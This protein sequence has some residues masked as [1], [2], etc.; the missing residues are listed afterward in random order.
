[1]KRHLYN[2]E[3]YEP[4]PIWQQNVSSKFSRNSETSASEFLEMFPLYFSKIQSRTPTLKPMCYPSQKGEHAKWCLLQH[5]E[6]FFSP[7]VLLPIFLSLFSCYYFQCLK[8]KYHLLPYITIY[9]HWLFLIRFTHL[10]VYLSK[11][12]W[13]FAVSHHYVVKDWLHVVLRKHLR[14]CSIHFK[15]TCKSCM[16]EQ[17]QLPVFK[18]SNLTLT[19]MLNM[20][21]NNPLYI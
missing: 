20:N 1:M 17:Q 16:Y 11:I 10:D 21:K 6:L 5:P 2:E 4:L 13:S 7:F 19:Q 9:Y 3:N 18:G 15:G 8:M 14:F 12:V